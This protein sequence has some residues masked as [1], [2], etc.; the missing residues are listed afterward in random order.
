MPRPP[1]PA[2]QP[3]PEY[4]PLVP[5][6]YPH[7]PSGH[8]QDLRNDSVMGSTYP[9]GFPSHSYPQPRKRRGNL[10]K[11]ATKIMKDWFAAHKDSP[12][13]SEEQKQS[14]VTQTRLNMSQVC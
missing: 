3:L 1:P 11:D 12:Y 5:G 10:P 2:Q 8:P 4:S 14:L 13:P 6:A 9:Y 7:G